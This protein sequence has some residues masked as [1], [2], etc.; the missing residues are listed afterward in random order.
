MVFR[1]KKP[2]MKNILVL[3]AGA[4]GTAIANLLAKNLSRKIY[5]WDL[6]E[7]VALSIN[8][9]NIN[10]KYL[11]EIRINKKVIGINSIE[12]VEASFIFIA[13]PSQHVY[14]LLKDLYSKKRKKVFSL[15]PTFVLCSKGIDLKRKCLLSDLIKKI[16]PT[17]KVAVLSGPTFAN[18]LANKKPTAATLAFKEQ[19]IG[20]ELSSMLCN[21][22]FKIY[23][24]SDLI[25]V[26]VNGTLKNVLAIAAGITDGL[27]L[28][29]NARAAIIS[30]GIQ[31]VIRVVV[32]LG[33]RKAT[34]LGLS[35]LGDIL[36]TCN[37]HNSRN[38]SMGY[39]LGKGISLSKILSSRPQVTEGLE[40]IKF[41]NFIGKKYKLH[42][43]IFE[44][45][46]KILIE[47]IPIPH[48]VNKLLD[49]TIKRE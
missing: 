13:T 1:G 12:K 10:F 20:R 36:L 41:I 11:P 43:P 30:R 47:N 8:E 35:G 45:V 9:K 23:T 18:T 29:E 16:D 2:F 44:S 25:G 24:T 33:G 39:K 21:R 48:E 22:Y 5:L 19:K 40:N 17:S 46:Y 4:W 42:I 7:Q 49:R 26:Q 3:G 31:E 37:S 34:V 28:G 27:G 15:N 32:C 6:E 38:F 14:D